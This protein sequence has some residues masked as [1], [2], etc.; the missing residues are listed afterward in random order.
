VYNKKP[1]PVQG[2][3]K[4]QVTS[5]ARKLLACP[6]FRDDMSLMCEPD[7]KN[8]Q[9]ILDYIEKETKENKK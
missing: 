5:L 2:L 9:A 4:Q 8:V 7:P 1:R 6:K 3:N